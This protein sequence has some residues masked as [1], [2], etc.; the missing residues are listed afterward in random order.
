MSRP[1]LAVIVNPSKFVDLGEVKSQVTLAATTAGWAEPHWFETRAD[2]PGMAATL[3]ALQTRP[4]L[5]C[6]MGGDGT[7]RAVA[8]ALRGTGIPLGLLPSGT[9]NLLARNLGIPLG[10]LPDALEVAF[11]GIDRTVDLGVATFDDGQERVFVVMAGVG[12]DADIMALTNDTLKRNV[13]SFAYVIGG[14]RAVFHRGFKAT[15]TVD[16]TR[17]PKRHSRMI[18]ACNCGSVMGS[19]GLAIDAVPDDGVLDA[20]LMR[21]RGI[22]GWTVV[23]LD[24]ATRHRRG[25]SAMLQWP[26]KDFAVQLDSPA[27]AEVDGDTV[28]PT[29]AARFSI[30]PGALVV[31]VPVPS[32]PTPG[33]TAQA[34]NKMREALSSTA[35]GA[36]GGPGEGRRQ[37]MDRLPGRPPPLQWCDTYDEPDAHDNLNLG[38]LHDTRNL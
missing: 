6:A 31:R 11:N 5:V 12:L 4:E 13:G 18:L 29:R 35:N 15:L 19:I 2:E 33:L 17:Q 28:G 36:N 8:S 21:P 32:D 27:L 1:T 34:M 10:S 16:G 22:T 7:V 3:Q 24:L 9:G 23:L 25:N 14:A 30:V 20:L 26:G 38:E 37:R